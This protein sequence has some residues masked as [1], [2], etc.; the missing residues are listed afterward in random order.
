MVTP[1]ILTY[2]REQRKHGASD[3]QIRRALQ[4]SGWQQSI[5]DEI[6]KTLQGQTAA[7]P[8]QPAVPEQQTPV[9]PI[10][11]TT[12][13][14]SGMNPSTL[15]QSDTVVKA[16]DTPKKSFPTKLIAGLVAG[17]LFLSVLGAGA[18]AYYMQLPAQVLARTV[19][20]MENVTSSEFSFTL[21][22]AGP[23]DS[24]TIL[25]N[26]AVSGI[27]PETQRMKLNLSSPELTRE[28]ELPS[29]SIDF[30]TTPTRMYTKI[31]IGNTEIIDEMG[32]LFNSWFHI[33]STQL[34]SLYR[35]SGMS[36]DEIAILKKSSEIS[37]EKQAKLMALSV[38]MYSTLNITKLD[39]DTLNGEPMYHYRYDVDK[40]K[41]MEVYAEMS[42][43][44]FE[45][46][47]S[48]EELTEFINSFNKI[49]GEILISKS[50][51]FVHKLTATFDL[52][53]GNSAKLSLDLKRHNQSVD[54]T[55]PTDSIDLMQLLG[56]LG[57]TMFS[58]PGMQET[59]VPTAPL[60]F[61]DF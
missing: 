8:E 61:G 27:T 60:G 54:I 28:L 58:A 4:Q 29:A 32:F 34:E 19:K 14:T 57:S 1:E 16:T 51:Y 11:D 49:S 37:K 35:E 25:G 53:N 41:F 31:S 22:A 39:D 52:R 23:T 15:S 55:E 47:A 7:V 10:A 24:Y 44:I 5:I 45:E 46:Q 18:Y 26:G 2:V 50:T 33:D 21:H 56:S 17:I 13:K 9:S 36:E 30:I 6:F 43:I 40:E 48:N 12:E 3:D 59:P 20:A 38:K 42:E